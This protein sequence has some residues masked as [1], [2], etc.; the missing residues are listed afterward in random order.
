M[1]SCGNDMREI[2]LVATNV[3]HCSAAVWQAQR[4]GSGYK[5]QLAWQTAWPNQP[6]WASFLVPGRQDQ[7]FSR[8]CCQ[9]D[10]L[11]H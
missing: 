11:P 4:A 9:L 10:R 8:V 6:S 2:R 7:A 5:I 1:A 3:H